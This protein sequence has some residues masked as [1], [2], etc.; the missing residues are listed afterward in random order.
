MQPPETRPRGGAWVALSLLLLILGAALYWAH[1]LDGDDAAR[2]H[3]ERAERPRS[4]ADERPDA[5]G[6]QATSALDP[7][8]VGGRSVGGRARFAA[9]DRPDAANHGSVIGHVR[10]RRT[11]EGVAHAELT[12]VLGD[13]AVTATSGSDGRYTLRPEREGT[14]TL[15]SASAPGYLPFAPTWGESAVRFACRPGEILEGATLWLEPGTEVLAQVVAPDGR[16]VPRAVVRVLSSDVAEQTLMPSHDSVETDV[17]GEARLTVADE[18]VLEASHPRFEPGRARVDFAARIAQRIRISLA[19]AGSATER[20]KAIAGRVVDARGAAIDGATVVASFQ[21]GPGESAGVRAPAI[22]V[23]DADGRF[24][25]SS[26]EAG[27]YRVAA[28]HEDYATARAQTVEAGRAELEIRLEDGGRIVGRVTDEAGAAV[29]GFTVQAFQPTGPL[30]RELVRAGSFFDRSGS[31]E[32]R[33]IPEGPIQVTVGAA[34]F[35]PSEDHP[36]MVSASRPAELAIVLSRGA[37][38]AGRVLDRDTRAAIADAE[39]GLDGSAGREGVS[40]APMF[41]K[42]RTDADGSFELVGVAQ[43]KRALLV[44]AP[45]HHAR[46]VSEIHVPPAGRVTLEPILLTK[47][48][49]NESPRLELAGLGAVLRPD[50]EGLRV[51][52][53]IEEGGAAEAGLI[54]GDLILH[55]DGQPVVAL[56]FERAIASIR[57]PI[58]SRVVLGVRRE[59]ARE[60]LQIVAFRRLVRA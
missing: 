37:L 26:L 16:P 59:G 11:G 4:S 42:A 46:I 56:G 49:A 40:A 9:T 22:D 18:A 13:A 38:L 34:G 41:S 44:A 21:A 30:E 51:E 27:R 12:F 58:D 23:S 5:R 20:A 55:I 25:L 3:G 28:R 31:F 7:L 52:R 57:G 60:A 24:L 45:E 36:V 14:L 53:V 35:A 29:L 39:I 2:D 54:P 48:E 50:G 6:D 33:A 32:L 17:R 15:L 47:L 10:N 1:A 19:A 8:R 43:G